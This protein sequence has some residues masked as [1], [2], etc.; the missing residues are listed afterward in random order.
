MLVHSPGLNASLVAHADWSI[1][2]K[3]RWMSVA[4]REG[5]RWR[6]RAEKVGPPDTLL[7]RLRDEA[8]G[9]PALFGVDAPIG[10]PQRYAALHQPGKRDFREFLAGLRA[11]DELFKVCDQIGEVSG[12]RPFFP[13]STHLSPRRAA[14]ATRLG[15]E[16]HDELM[17]RCDIKTK[18]R[19]RAACLFWTLGPNQVGKAALSFWRELLLPALHGAEPPALWPFDGE[20]HDLLRTRPITVAETYPAE[21][22]SA[23]KPR[24]PGSKRRHSDRAGLADDIGLWLHRHHATPTPA[25]AADIAAGFGDQTDGEDRFDSLIGLLG[26]LAVVQDPARGRAPDDAA[27]RWEGWI[28][29]QHCPG[30]ASLPS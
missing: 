16:H 29:G 24:W 1:A 6:V 11:E 13:R 9:R 30:S 17:R 14:Q 2:E 15:V 12:A 25:L 26:M 7:D 3:K 23:L 20:L 5:P 10:L 8:A 4:T 21:A 28:L 27:I 19:P 18:S 22:L